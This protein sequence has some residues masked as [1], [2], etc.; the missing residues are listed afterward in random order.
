MNV[1]KKEAGAIINGIRE[2]VL[3]KLGVTSEGEAIDRKLG[4]NFEDE[5][6]KTVRVKELNQPELKFI[7]ASGNVVKKIDLRSG[8]RREVKKSHSK[9]KTPHLVEEYCTRY[10]AISDDGKYALYSESLTE[11][12]MPE[13][14][15]EMKSRPDTYADDIGT[16][17]VVKYFDASGSLLWERNPP[18]DTRVTEA[19][20]SDGGAITAYLQDSTKIGSLQENQPSAELV[21][22]GKDGGVLF[23]FPAAGSEYVHWDGAKL[24]MASS[25]RYLCAVGWRNFD[26]SNYCFDINNKRTW[27][28]REYYDVRGIRDNGKVEVSYADARK[29]GRKIINL[30]KY[31]GE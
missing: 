25:G 18:P 15:Q 13:Y 27:A 9:P 8:F 20:I 19:Q 1:S 22:V 17:T 14:E 10:A 5:M 28:S 23:S 6:K 2:E 26:H 7:D 16:T 30:E 29:K 24:L 3:K 31:L 12:L 4:R 11:G 21:V